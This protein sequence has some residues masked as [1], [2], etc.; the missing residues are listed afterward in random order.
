MNGASS[1]LRSRSL[2]GFTLLEMVLVLVVLA[3]ILAISVPQLRGFLAGSRSRDAVSQIVSLAQYA[4][5][6]AAADSTVYRLNVDGSGYWLTMQQGESYMPV[7]TEFGRRFALPDG[8]T[9]A[10]TPTNGPTPIPNRTSGDQSPFDATGILFYPDGRTSAGV[11]RLT[12]PDGSVTLLAA[13]SPA[14]SFRVVT[15][16]EA[17]QL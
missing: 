4:K 13:M 7:G 3:V 15:P 6:R 16:Q 5:A 14:E 11:I 10:L 1:Q 2:R 8:A 17:A 12:E 9:V